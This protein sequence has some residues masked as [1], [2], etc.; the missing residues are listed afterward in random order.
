MY[1]SVLK[2]VT[3]SIRQFYFNYCECK[4]FSITWMFYPFPLHDDGKLL[5]ITGNA[6]VLDGLE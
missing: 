6:W 2:Y 1:L 4:H 3:Y 5:L